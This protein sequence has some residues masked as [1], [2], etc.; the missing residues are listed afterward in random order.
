MISGGGNNHVMRW[1]ITKVN[2]DGDR[3]LADP[4]QGRFTYATQQEA[5][6]RL[7]AI[8]SSPNNSAD[9]LRDVF[10]DVSTLAV[11]CVPCHPRHFDPI[12]I[13]AND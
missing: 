7:D 12:G 13:Y 8:T 10:G 11:R 5:Q 6:A 9:T 1:V 4:A 2:K 3:V